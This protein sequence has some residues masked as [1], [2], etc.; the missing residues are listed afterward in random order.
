MDPQKGNMTVPAQIVKQ[1]PAKIIDSPAENYRD[2]TAKVPIEK[3]GWI[4]ETTK[5]GILSVAARRVS[6]EKLP[7]LDFRKA[8]KRQL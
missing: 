6:T 1:I 2:A 4:A 8:P 7:V 3:F 5:S